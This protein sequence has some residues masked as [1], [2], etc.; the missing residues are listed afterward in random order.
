LGSYSEQT[1]QNYN[2]SA[3]NA[4]RFQL[5]Y[6]LLILMLLLSIDTATEYAGVCL[7]GDKDIL[8][9]KENTEQK[10]HA[11]FVQPAIAAMLA[12][13]ALK[14]QDIDGVV[15]SN[16]PGS[17]TGLRVGLASA[18]GI[19]YALNK[20]LILIN[21]LKAMA[22]ASVEVEQNKSALYCPMIDARRMEVF[23]AVYTFSLEEKMSPC[24]LVIEANSFEKFLTN[25]TVIFSGNG[26]AKCEKIIHHPNAKF[27]SVQHSVKQVATLGLEAFLQKDFADP[28][29]SEPFYFKEFY[30]LVKK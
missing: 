5:K 15:V 1:S 28:A 30:T 2:A 20:P 21:T 4:E 29:Y 27:S 7:S 14:L 24:S 10:N 11:S 13:T 8:S 19:C 18:K 26:A 16:G 6:L 3:L 22:L 23:T 9:I 17:Y 25:Y 12:E